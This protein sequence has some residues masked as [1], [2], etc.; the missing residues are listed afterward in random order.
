MECYW[1]LVIELSILLECDFLDPPNNPRIIILTLQ[2]RKLRNKKV[3]PCVRD[4]IACEKQS[5]NTTPNLADS[6][7]QAQSHYALSSCTS[8]GD[9]AHPESFNCHLYADH[10]P[11]LY[12][13]PRHFCLALA[14]I[15]NWWLG[16]FYPTGSSNLPGPKQKPSFPQEICS[17]AC[18]SF[19]SFLFF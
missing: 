14:N 6:K 17:S 1:V 12:L 4:H 9:H 2:M 3:K 7:A 15:W 8:L 16:Y 18:I 19:L 5:W 10:F 11:H 13:Q